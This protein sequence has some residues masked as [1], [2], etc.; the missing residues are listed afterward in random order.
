MLEDFVLI[1]WGIVRISIAKNKENITLACSIIFSMHGGVPKVH[2]SFLSGLH[3]MGNIKL[4]YG[5]YAVI[6]PVM[7]DLGKT[8][9]NTYKYQNIIEDYEIAKKFF[10]AE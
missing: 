9:N 2:Y 5:K 3:S 8:E 10:T 7:C 1:V 4:F 6:S